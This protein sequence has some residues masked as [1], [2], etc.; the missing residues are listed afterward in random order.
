MSG[1]KADLF[2]GFHDFLANM[3]DFKYKMHGI[4]VIYMPCEAMNLTVEEACKDKELLKRLKRVVFHWTK[5]IRL[6]LADLEPTASYELPCLADEF[7]FWQ[8]RR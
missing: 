3:T 2:T 8:Y 1:V 7:Q 4:T 5:Q 6:A